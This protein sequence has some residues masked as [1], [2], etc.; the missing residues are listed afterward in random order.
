MYSQILTL[1]IAGTFFIDGALHLYWAVSGRLP[2]DS[3]I[4]RDEDGLRLFDP[5]PAITIAS[6]VMQWIAALIVVLPGTSIKLGL[7]ALLFMRAMG[8]LHYI[9][10]FKRV[11]SS[12]Y[13]RLDTWLYSPLCLAQAAGIFWLTQFS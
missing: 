1:L 13:A 11:R 8:E 9:G 10:F 6:G 4:P 12:R 2:E 7:A 3:V 5:E